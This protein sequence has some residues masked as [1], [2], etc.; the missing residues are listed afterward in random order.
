MA[1]ARRRRERA[2]E[3]VVLPVRAAALTILLVRILAPLGVPPAAAMPAPIGL[4]ARAGF[5]RA[6]PI[7]AGHELFDL[8]RIVP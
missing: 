5:W 3:E 4:R 1:P 2:L 8:L 7:P 6:A